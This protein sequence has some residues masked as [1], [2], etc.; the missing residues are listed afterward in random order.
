MNHSSSRCVVPPTTEPLSLDEVKEHLRIESSAEDALLQ[1][2]IEAV[3][4][5]CEH[6]TS[7]VLITQTWETVFDRFPGLVLESSG[8]DGEVLTL[9]RTQRQGL[10]LTLPIG[11]IQA[12]ESIRYR[13]HNG[14]W[15]TLAPD[16]YVRDHVT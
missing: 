12:V 7:R 14:E 15:Q 4:E 8:L 1:V 5:I 2:Y 9:S 10:G 6:N 13:D 16:A 3:R 11:P